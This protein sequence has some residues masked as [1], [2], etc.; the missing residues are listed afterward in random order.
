MSKRNDCLIDTGSLVA[1]MEA[2]LSEI[3]EEMK[4]FRKEMEKQT[5]LLGE[6]L[7]QGCE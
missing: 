5:K 4:L 1:T 3:A 7:K 2:C 6:I